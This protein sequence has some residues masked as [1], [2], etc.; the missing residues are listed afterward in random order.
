[1][2]FDLTMATQF[3]QRSGPLQQSW[4]RHAGDFHHAPGAP[5]QVQ[6]NG[7]EMLGAHWVMDARPHPV[8]R[9][10]FI[11]QHFEG[12]E[13]TADCDC[14]DPPALELMDFQ[15]SSQGLIT[16]TS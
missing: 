13:T 6:L 5:G 11:A 14:F 15:P 2:Q 3:L 9:T 1:M 8:S 7:G 4:F 16:P 12:W 10:S